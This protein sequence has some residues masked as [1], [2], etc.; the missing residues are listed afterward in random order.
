MSK[1]TFIATSFFSSNDWHETRLLSG[2]EAVNLQRCGRTQFAQ[3]Q[4]AVVHGS[5]SVSANMDQLN[6]RPSMGSGP[7]DLFADMNTN[8]FPSSPL[9]SAARQRIQQFHQNFKLGEFQS[10]PNINYGANAL[11]KFHN[12]SFPDFNSLFP[13]FPPPPDITFGGLFPRTGDFFSSMTSSLN[14]NYQPHVASQFSSNNNNISS[15][16]ST[17]DDN[18]VLSSTSQEPKSTENSPSLSRW[19]K[20]PS[21]SGFIHHP[22]QHTQPGRGSPDYQ[23]PSSSSSTPS[24]TGTMSSTSSSSVPYF[25]ESELRNKTPPFPHQ[26]DQ[27]T[28]SKMSDDNQWWELY[29]PN[30]TRF[31]YYN[32]TSQ[33]TVWHKP[34]NCDIIP[35][36]KLQT[37]KQNTEV[38]EGEREN[39]KKREMGTQTPLTTP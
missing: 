12:F 9:L 31:Y 29:D 2:S 5:N 18:R 34:Q 25:S 13:D 23:D 1:E 36:A 15:S 38:K 4:G 3:N 39:S 22:N 30:T 6:N 24:A 11:Q 32:A 10:Q 28:K 33:K 14:A 17:I 16:S 8:F 7:F 19:V 37:L 20:W 26:E 21:D 27:S 35:L